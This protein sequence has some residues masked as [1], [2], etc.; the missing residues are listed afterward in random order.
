MKKKAA[1]IHARAKDIIKR[2]IAQAHRPDAPEA[3]TEYLWICDEVK[4]ES[5]FP[6]RLEL[7]VALVHYLCDWYKK[8]EEANKT[9]SM[10]KFFIHM[11]YFFYCIQFEQKYMEEKVVEPLIKIEL[12]VSVLGSLIDS[13]LGHADVQEILLYFIN[14]KVLVVALAWK[15]Y[16]YISNRALQSLEERID[17]AFSPPNTEVPA[18]EKY[19]KEKE[20]Y[21]IVQSL[22]N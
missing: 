3:S 4:K 15:D 22:M 17:Q 8:Q 9:Q 11:I 20:A 21:L 13:A 12:P 1:G 6:K 16:Q 10:G 18:L 14:E 19:V 5:S 7:L 2:V